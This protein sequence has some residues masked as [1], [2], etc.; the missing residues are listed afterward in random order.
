MFALGDIEHDARKIKFC[1]MF[2]GQMGEDIE[3]V[4]RWCNMGGGKKGFDQQVREWDGWKGH[5][6]CT[7]AVSKG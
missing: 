3:S 5:L 6:D 4:A 1:K 2:I 7:E